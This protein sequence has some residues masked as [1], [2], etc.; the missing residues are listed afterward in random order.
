MVIFGIERQVFREEWEFVLA[1]NGI[2]VIPAHDVFEKGVEAMLAPALAR[3]LD[4]ANGLYATL[5]IDVGAR[6]VVP[7]TG[8]QTGVIGLSPEQMLTVAM[9]LADKPLK[10][11]DVTELSPPL[12]PSGH[13]AGLAASMLLR[14]L[15]P[16]LYEQMDFP[17]AT[18]TGS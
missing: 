9:L 13:T 4:G 15:R 8:N 12:D 3:A 6:S 2:Q 5:D 10:G 16:R 18:G 1:S 14:V 17:T 11:V 7:G